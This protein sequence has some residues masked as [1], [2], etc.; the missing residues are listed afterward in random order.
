MKASASTTIDR[1][2]DDVFAYVSDVENTSEWV[3]GVGDTTLVDGDGTGVGDRYESEYTYGGNT[4]DMDFEITDY[5]PPRRLGMTAPEG[6]FAFD[7]TLELEAVDGGTRVTNTIET[8]S[9]GLFTTITFTV[10]RPVM[11]WLMA[12]RLTQELDELKAILE[13]SDAAPASESDR[14]T[15]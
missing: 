3:A 2:I 9:D 11:R 7:G 8:G 10:F 5:D 13:T 4:S 1:P 14:A 6:P 12:R 15:A